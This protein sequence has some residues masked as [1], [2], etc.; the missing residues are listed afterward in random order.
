A[1]MLSEAI[2]QNLKPSDSKESIHLT[3]W[4]SGEEDTDFEKALLDEMALAQEIINIGRSL[5]QELKIKIRQPLSQVIVSKNSTLKYFGELVLSELNVKEIVYVEQEE[6]VKLNTQ[7]SEALLSEGL[8]RE[9][10]HA[11]QNLR[12]SSGLEVDDRISLSLDFMQDT[13]LAKL[14]NQ[15]KDY[16]SRELLAVNWSEGALN[17]TSGFSKIV[18]VNEKQ[19]SVTISKWSN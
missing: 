3:D 16:I 12:K 10:I 11:I 9:L 5:R 4:I 1:P 15:Q 19:V 6:K 18:K 13:D 8:A 7:L 17:H 14:L 2:Y